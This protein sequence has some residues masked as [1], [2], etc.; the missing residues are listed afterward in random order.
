VVGLLDKFSGARMRIIPGTPEV[1]AKSHIFGAD[2][3]GKPAVPGREEWT[4]GGK[5]LPNGIV[6]SLSELEQEGVGRD[7]AENRT[8]C[9]CYGSGL[10]GR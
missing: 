10:G 3:P 9:S 8:R 7:R 4:L 6:G 5:V 1:P 2:E